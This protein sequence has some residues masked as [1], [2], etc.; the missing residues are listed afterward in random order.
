MALSKYN[1]QW[2][3][4]CE[5]EKVS[6]TFDEKVDTTSVD[7]DRL[8]KARYESYLSKVEKQMVAE[9]NFVRAYPTVYAKIIARYM[10]DESKGIWGLHKDTYDAGMELIREL[11]VLEPASILEPMECVYRA[12]ENHGIFCKERGF[13][14]HEGR[15]GSDPWDR[16]TREC[17]ELGTGNENGAANVSLHPRAAVISLLLDDGISSRGHRYNMLNPE[18]KYIGCY[19]YVAEVTEHYTLYQW[20]QK[21]AY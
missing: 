20:I 14:D 6:F 16:V 18:W 2:G 11:K 19:Q 4:T 9:V 3:I 10:S 13:F 8:N 1:F 12:A 15:N 17:P 21:F 7:F 5:R